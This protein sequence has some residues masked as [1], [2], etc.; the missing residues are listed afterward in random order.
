MKPYIARIEALIF[1]VL[2]GILLTPQGVNAQQP[3]PGGTV[4]R[5]EASESGCAITL[6]SNS[7][8]PTVVAVAD[9]DVCE[10]PIVGQKIQFTYSA[11]GITVTPPP[12]VGTVSMLESGDHACY[13]DLVDANGESTLQF[14]RFEICQQNILNTEVRLTYQPD[15]IYAASCQGDL[16]CKESDLVLLITQ[17][18]PT[19]KVPTPPQSLISSL[20]DGNYRYWN[21]R[22]SGAIVTDDELLAKG[23]VTFTFSKKGRD[24][25]G[26]FGYVDGRA[27][28]VQGQ[29]NENTVTGISVESNAG[30][31][32]MSTGETFEQFGPGAF[33]KVRRGRQLP[34]NS[35]IIV[36][37]RR[38]P[39]DVVRYDST[40][41]D[42]R[43][44]TRINAGTSVPPRRC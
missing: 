9:A 5:V 28:C 27:I 8:T 37:G 4:S 25:V 32:P 20:P 40:L 30:A 22:P 21:G 35:A 38:V 29:V 42:L 10:Q 19:G 3:V 18:E 39:I 2:S 13:V 43:G 36:E 11:T 31:S 7:A 15:S 41:L 24:V 23:G 44:L 14:A 33:L 1:A 6:Q 12:E 16:D 34:S 26:V 17:A